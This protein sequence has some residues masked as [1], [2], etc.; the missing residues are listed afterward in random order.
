MALKTSTRGE[1]PPFIVMEVMRAAAEREAQGGHVYHLEVGQPGSTAPKGVIEAAKQ[2]L[3]SHRLGYT[4]ALGIPEL[5]KAIADHYARD[6]GVVVPEDRIVVTT[7]SSGGFLLSFLAAFDQG[8]KVAL[9]APGYPCYRHILTA[10]G[11]Q[12]VI[13]ETTKEDR[14]QPSPALLEKAQAEHGPIDGLI[15]ASP[16]NPT[17]TM[18]SKED[19]AALADY[20][21]TAGI[22]LISD[23]IYQGIS[24]GRGFETVL[25]HTDHAVVVNSFS[26]YFAMTGWRLGWLVLPEDLLRP[27]ECLA[28]NLF[29]SP[30]TLS[31]VA[32]VA[33]FDCR[34]ELESNIARYAANRDLLLRELPE[35]GFGDLAPSDGAFY[36]YADVGH[37]TNDS[38]SFCSRI[39]KETGAAVTPGLDFDEARGHRTMRFSFSGT[40]EEISA[41]AQAL[42]AWRP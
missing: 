41:A 12:P 22:R 16:S 24:Y 18:L 34:E 38:L 20:C 8:D 21:G 30:P 28:Q 39:L 14:Y 29:I 42:K 37:M 17:G 27:V 36:L 10:L 35:A 3:D 5:R 25:A 23:E 26:K 2:A 19:M 15:V 6:Y 32:A 7:G 9:V 33:A 13:I 1:I 31:Q 4:V 40:T 11:I